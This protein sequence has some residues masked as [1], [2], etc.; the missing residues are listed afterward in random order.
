MIATHELIATLSANLTPVKRL[1]P[2]IFRAA[3]WL[4]LAAFVL[5]LVGMSHG[6]RPDITQALKDYS[7]LLRLTGAVVTGLLS[8]IATFMLVMPDRSRWWA[9][10]PVPT[11]VFWMMTVGQQCLT[12]WVAL[13]PDGIS[14]GESAECF[15]TLALTSLP[16]SLAMLLMFRRAGPLNPRLVALLGGVAVAGIAASALSLFHQADASAMILLFNVGTA[17]MFA[18]LGSALSSLVLPFSQTLK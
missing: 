8:A 9:F 17:L 18:G 14:L 10:L 3:S 15:A 7:F 5:V 12:S 2:P 4:I 6:V 16:I 11:L 13:G 1:Q